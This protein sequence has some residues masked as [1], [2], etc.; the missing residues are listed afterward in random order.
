MSGLPISPRTIYNPHPVR[1]GQLP[2]PWSSCPHLGIR[3][4]DL[5]LQFLHLLLQLFLL[6]I[7]TLSITALTLEVLLKDLHLQRGAEEGRQ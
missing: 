6:L 4:R 1:R 3:Q 7:H 5:G 2:L